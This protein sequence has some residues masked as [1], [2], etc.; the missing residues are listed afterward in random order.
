[1]KIHGIT[2]VVLTAVRNRSL[3]V[4]FDDTVMFGW[5]FYVMSGGFDGRYA[6]SHF[7][8]LPVVPGIGMA[9]EYVVPALCLR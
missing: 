1:M 6:V 9:A 8:R 5:M 4:V 7:C 2:T 3:A